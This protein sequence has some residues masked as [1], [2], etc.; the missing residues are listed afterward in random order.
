MRSLAMIM[1]LSFVALLHTGCANGP[2]SRF[3][4]GGECSTCS[5]SPAETY[6]GAYAIETGAST[7]ATCNTNAAS[8]NGM[9]GGNWGSGQQAVIANSPIMG[10]EINGAFTGQSISG[11]FPVD[12]NFSGG[13]S[14][15]SPMPN[16]PGPRN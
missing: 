5:A 9:F 3:M 6:T 14:S 4:R 8:A 15:V 16:L 7:C 11:G 2:L 12:S 10:N 1:V 13:F